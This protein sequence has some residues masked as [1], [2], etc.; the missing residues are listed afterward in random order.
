M[1]RPGKAQHGGGDLFSAA[2]VMLVYFAYMLAI[3]FVPDLLAEPIAKGS[4][5][6]LGLASGVVMALFMVVFAA[7]YTHRRNS[8]EGDGESFA[9]RH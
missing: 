5:I 1:N 3:A 2:V 7:W 6:S 9:I 8:R 4:T